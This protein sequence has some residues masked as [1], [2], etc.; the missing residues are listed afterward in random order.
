[1]SVEVNKEAIAEFLSTKLGN[2]VKPEDLSDDLL[3][4]WVST[5]EDEDVEDNKEENATDKKPKNPEQSDNKSD[6]ND[7]GDTGADENEDNVDESEIDLSA[8]NP[9]N[10]SELEKFLYNKLIEQD[11]E[12]RVKEL[13][14]VINSSGVNDKFKAVLQRMADN[15]VEIEEIEKTIADF[16]EIEKSTQRKK[17]N[18]TLILPRSKTKGA[19]TSK[20]DNNAPKV[21]TVEF[22]KFLAKKK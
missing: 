16:K 18:N 11:E 20:K 2:T 13:N 9:E 14:T 15:G 4:G 8:L 21:G 7:D 17:G 19:G 12:H 3:A 10:M 1:M 6:G 22:G 5:V